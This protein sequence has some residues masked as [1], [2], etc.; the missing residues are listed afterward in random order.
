MDLNLFSCSIFFQIFGGVFP[1]PCHHALDI[2]D[3]QY[4]TFDCNGQTTHLSETFKPTNKGCEFCD[5]T[6]A[7]PSC[8]NCEKLGERGH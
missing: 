6:N 2:I 1:L 4:L 7:H 8:G 3:I 5:Y